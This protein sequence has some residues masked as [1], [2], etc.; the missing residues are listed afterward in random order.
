[1]T[2]IGVGLLTSYAGF[3]ADFYKHEI[4]NSVAEIESI[5]TPVHV[6]IFVGMF[7]A[8][9]GFFWALRRTQ[10]RALPAA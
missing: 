8:A 6:P 3:A 2:V 1:M 9:I 7:I 5:W 4:E 10:P